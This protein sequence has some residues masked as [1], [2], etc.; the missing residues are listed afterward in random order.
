MKSFVFFPKY[1]VLAMK[2]KMFFIKETKVKNL[3][4]PIFLDFII[5]KG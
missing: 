4:P 5:M 2:A 3:F 1:Y